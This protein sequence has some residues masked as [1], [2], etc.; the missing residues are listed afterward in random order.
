MAYITYDTIMTSYVASSPW[1][2]ISSL[3]CCTLRKVYGTWQLQA[4]KAK[5]S[6]LSDCFI[7]LFQ[8][9]VCHLLL[10]WSYYLWP[11]MKKTTYTT[12]NLWPVHMHHFLSIYLLSIGD[13]VYTHTY[14]CT[15]THT[16][17]PH[18]KWV[19]KHLYYKKRLAI[20]L[21]AACCSFLCTTLIT[22]V[23]TSPRFT[24]CLTSHVT[25]TIGTVPC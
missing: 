20:T 5:Q 14:K 15:H 13:N 4:T 2:A 7:K 1:Q 16:H 17:T 22:R 18:T 25:V 8:G 3:Q 21:V 10:K 24:G 6:L 19:H 23:K 11:D 12:A 9:F